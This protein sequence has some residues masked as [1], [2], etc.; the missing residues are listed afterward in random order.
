[1]PKRKRSF[2]VLIEAKLSVQ[3]FDLES[4]R[5]KVE[6]ALAPG[7]LVDTDVRSSGQV[8]IYDESD[9]AP[10]FGGRRA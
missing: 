2:E 4:A 5:R 1:M 8:W 10:S 6:R 9:V 7:R 3:A